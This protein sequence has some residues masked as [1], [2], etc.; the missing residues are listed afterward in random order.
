M[1]ETGSRRS[2]LVSRLPIFRR[3]SHKRQ[4]SLPS[5]PSSGGVAN[6]VHTSS[7]SSTNSSSSSTGKRRSLF[8]TPSISFHSRR[9][10]EARADPAPA[11]QEHGGRGPEPGLHKSEDGSRFKT[12]HSFGFGS[13]RHKKITRSQTEDFE[14]GPTNRSLFINCISSGTNEGDDSG[15]LDD[16][17]SKRSFR[18]KKQLLPKSFSSHHRFSKHSVG[19][20]DQ[21]QSLEVNAEPPKP[22]T[23]GS[24]PSEFGDGSL[25]SP[26]LSEDRTTAITPSEFVPVTEDSVSEVDAMPVLS[27]AAVLEPVGHVA[28]TSSVV[29]A[30]TPPILE[31]PALPDASRVSLECET[32]AQQAPPTAPGEGAEPDATSRD[33]P[34]GD[35]LIVEHREPD[36]AGA[37]DRPGEEM[38][39]RPKNVVPMQEAR[40][41]LESRP[42]HLR[43]PHTVSVGSS[44]SPHHEVKRLERRLRSA[45]EGAGGTGGPRLHLSL[46]EPHFAEG[47][48]LLQH[49]TSSSS[50]KLG[51][52]DVLNNLGSSEL[53]EDDLMLDLD[54]SDDQRQHR[55]SREDSSQS[56]ASCLALLHSPMEPT[57]DKVLGKEAKGV[58]SLYREPVR[59]TSLLPPDCC[60]PR[61]DELLGLEGLPLRLMMQ[62][63]T[64]VKTLLLRLRKLLQESTETSPASSLHSLPI[65]P[66]SDMSLP[67]KDPVRDENSS[68][69][70]QLK[71][72][73]ELI[74]RLQ[75]EL[76]KVRGAQRPSCSRADKSTQTEPG[77]PEAFLP[78]HTPSQSAS[79]RDRRLGRPL[80]SDRPA[81]ATPVPAS[82]DRKC[83]G[84]DAPE[85]V[86]LRKVPDGPISQIPRAVQGASGSGL[87]GRAGSPSQG[88]QSSDSERGPRG[89]S[90]RAAMSRQAPATASFTGRLG[91]PPRGPLS[92]HMYSRKNVFLQHSLHTAELQALAQQDS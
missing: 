44:A 65:S 85:T 53:D 7:P 5:S 19:T 30:A 79:L 38:G 41:G 48:A 88:S 46:R 50:S 27:P 3:S 90:E 64:S 31:K 71:D 42:S 75:A 52:L 37:E 69:L 25:Q 4:D 2:T 35:Q 12:R 29:P 36:T 57:T 70:L 8:R 86:G 51:S 43:K 6:G 62:D 1:G 21:C 9:G 22:P 55:V 84:R 13:H 81:S 11:A 28:P 24:C 56:L 82:E 59:P 10:Q 89:G 60:L 61:D 72:R 33:G 49:R 76:E 91:Q 17:S 20:P 14:K 18:H 87:G 67:F 47:Q 23:P 54:L 92:L 74:Q 16:Y 66:C 83:P 39:R 15:F 78:N 32:A 73:D 34:G 58:E 80:L 68:L 26:M 63:C 40:K 77:S 45:S